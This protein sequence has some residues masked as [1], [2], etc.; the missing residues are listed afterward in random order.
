MWVGG[1]IIKDPDDS[2]VGLTVGIVLTVGLLPSFVRTV[3]AAFMGTGGALGEVSANGEL[4]GLPSKRV[5]DSN[6]EGHAPYVFGET[7]AS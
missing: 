6:G 2:P 1:F 7:N 3:V 5:R 4:L